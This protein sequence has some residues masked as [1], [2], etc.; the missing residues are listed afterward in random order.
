VLLSQTIEQPD[1]AQEFEM[2][3]DARLALADHLADLTDG[4]LG[5]RKQREQPEPRGL[6]SGT[7]C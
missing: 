2:P 5:A 1:I 4:Q 7:Q 6:G 3:R